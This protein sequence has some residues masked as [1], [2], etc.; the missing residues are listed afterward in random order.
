LHR[1]EWFP[2]KRF[3]LEV[4]FGGEGRFRGKRKE[5]RKRVDQ[6]GGGQKKPN[7]FSKIGGKWTKRSCLKNKRW[8][9]KE[10]R[11]DAAITGDNGGNV[12]SSK[13]EIVSGK[14]AG[15][16]TRKHRQKDGPPG[17]GKRQTWVVGGVNLLHGKRRQHTRVKNRG[18][19]G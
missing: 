6:G 15:C 3:V 17:D 14:K 9:V 8:E 4:L 11:A 16:T 13:P 5:K 1:K 7:I 12:S 10:Q 2:A 19:D 18:Q